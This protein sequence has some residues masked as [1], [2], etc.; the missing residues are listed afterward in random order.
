M[1]VN[2]ELDD[3]HK[4]LAILAGAP[5]ATVNPLMMAIGEQLRQQTPKPNGPLE[6]SVAP[7]E[8]TRQ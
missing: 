5:W 4:V 6:P 2:L 7:Q 8:P 3:W 1:T